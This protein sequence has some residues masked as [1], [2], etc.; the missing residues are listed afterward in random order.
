[1]AHAETEQ[2]PSGFPST[3][4][5][6][7]ADRDCFAGNPDLLE[8]VECM[9]DGAI[10]NE[11]I[12]VI[13]ASIKAAKQGIPLEA[14]TYRPVKLELAAKQSVHGNDYVLAKEEPRRIMAEPDIDDEIG[15]V[16][17]RIAQCAYACGTEAACPLRTAKAEPEDEYKEPDWIA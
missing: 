11:W 10:R 4:G 3:A 16:R 15:A 2:F 12:D 8:E 1:M 5:C 9:D 14:A 17:L 7:S 13:D 6:P